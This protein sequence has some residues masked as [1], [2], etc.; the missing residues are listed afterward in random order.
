MGCIERLTEKLMT[1]FNSFGRFT[2]YWFT[3]AAEVEVW[4]R[5]VP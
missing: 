1:R 3:G 5:S 2:R 4:S